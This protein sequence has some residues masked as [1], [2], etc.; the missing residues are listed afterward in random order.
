[1]TFQGERFDRWLMASVFL[2]GALAAF[3]ILSGKIFPSFSPNWGSSTGGSGGISAKIVN[4][5]PGVPLPTPEVVT[6]NAPANELPGLNKSEPAPPPLPDKTAEPVPLRT[7]P[8]ATPKPKPA[9]P[10]Q[11]AP[12]AS[13]A[14]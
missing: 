10:Q 7:A 12:P 1:M 4:N 13:K 6:E 2:H 14:A 8:K 11:A 5:M 9:P 3:V